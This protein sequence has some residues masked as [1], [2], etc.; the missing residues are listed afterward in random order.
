MVLKNKYINKIETILRKIVYESLNEM[1]FER[2]KDP[3]GALGVGRRKMIEDWL[4][5]MGIMHYTIND[6]MTID[7]NSN[8]SIYTQKS[9]EKSLVKFPDFIQFNEVNG[10]F[11]CGYN[12]LVSLR[13]CSKVV[14]ANFNCIHNDLEYLEG[15]PEIVNGYFRC[16]DNKVEFT[17]EYVLSLCDVRKNWIIN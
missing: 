15:C 5:E 13:G 2:R 8:V 6:D 7:T 1:N 10:W 3:L 16:H 4:D 9:H 17:K 11:D 14:K 12:S